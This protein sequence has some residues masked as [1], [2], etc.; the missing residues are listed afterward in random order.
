MITA[1]G[2]KDWRMD[3]RRPVTQKRNTLALASYPL[4]SLEMARVRRDDTKKML[5][6]GIDPAEDRNA[7]KEKKKAQAKNIF[8]RY[9]QDWLNKRAI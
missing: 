3:Y 5:I 4:I 1:N 9:A 8:S 7:N 6:N 2:S